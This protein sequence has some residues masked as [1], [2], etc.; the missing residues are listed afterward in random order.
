MSRKFLTNI[1]MNA[2]QI[3]NLVLQQLATDPVSPSTG[4]V[5]FHT[6]SGQVKYYSGTAT[7]VLYD[8][9]TTNTSSKAV[10]RDSGGSFAANVGTFNSVTINN[11]PSSATDAATKSYVDNTVQDRK[12]VV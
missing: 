6:G 12:S 1:D 3:L 9:A 11:S 2:N 8:S 10:L 7:I 4:Q 5:W